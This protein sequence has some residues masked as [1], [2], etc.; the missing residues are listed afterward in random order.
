MVE[1]ISSRR[2]LAE[3]AARGFAFSRGV[4]E[5]VSGVGT[6]TLNLLGIV[7]LVPDGLSLYVDECLSICVE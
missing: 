3:F 1:A 5:S 7:R 6:K 4:R 2:V